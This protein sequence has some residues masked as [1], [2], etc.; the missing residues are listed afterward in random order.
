MAEL[1]SSISEQRGC[2]GLLLSRSNSPAKGLRRTTSP[3]VRDALCAARQTDREFLTTVDTSSG[4]TFLFLVRKD[5]EKPKF[6][7]RQTGP[8]TV[9]FEMKLS[10]RSPR[11]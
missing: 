7:L 10:D 1:L 2:G 5:L 3:C 6:W 11:F 8:A 9:W 4:T